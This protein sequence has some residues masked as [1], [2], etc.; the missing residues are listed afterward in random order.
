MTEFDVP[1]TIGVLRRPAGPAARSV[2]ELRNGDRLAR[3]EFER[4]Y[5]ARSDVKKAELIEGV[6]HMPSP[7]HL[8]AHA[9]PHSEIQGVLLVY[10]AFTPGVHVADNATVRLDPD[11][12]L[13]PDVLLRLGDEAG[14]RSRVSEDDYLEGAP[15]LIVEVAASRAPI[16]M[17]A[18]RDVYR[19]S[20]VQEYVV[21]Q[22]REKRIDWFA[23]SD[24]EYHPLPSDR[25]GIIRSRAFPGLRLALRALLEGDP[26][27]A[28]AEL[29]KGLQ[30]PEHREFVGRLAGKS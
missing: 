13:Q 11:N 23:L 12:E 4:R 3:G 27:S 14:G 16:D 7:V 28:L 8:T 9:E 1:S 21:W 5:A 29:D 22:T 26:A 2:P 25:E 18:K 17:R 30:S 20:G 15:E 10:A 19:R 24:G 6:V